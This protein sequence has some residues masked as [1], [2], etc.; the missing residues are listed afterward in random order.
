MLYKWY[1]YRR[2]CH[3]ARLCLLFL[4]RVFDLTF[5]IVLTLHKY[6]IIIFTSRENLF[7]VL[8][9]NVDI[10]SAKCLTWRG[11]AVSGLFT[12]LICFQGCWIDVQDDPQHDTGSSS[13]YLVVT[14][15]N[16]RPI[17]VTASKELNT[18]SVPAWCPL[19]H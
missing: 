10:L 9:L 16:F 13:N 17:N 6:T 11:G 3:H 1:L 5:R 7:W 8:G 2:C 12:L 15:L 19:Q 18:Q 14:S 4:L